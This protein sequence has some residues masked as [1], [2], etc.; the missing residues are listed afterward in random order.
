MCKVVRAAAFTDWVTA[1]RRKLLE[2]GELT[3]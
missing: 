3:K 2:T 1:V